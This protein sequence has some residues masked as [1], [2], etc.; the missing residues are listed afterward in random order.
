MNKKAAIEQ[1]ISFAEQ[2]YDSYG[3]EL[4]MNLYERAVGNEFDEAMKEYSKLGEQL[5]NII[6]E[7]K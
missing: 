1:L 4:E 6:E 5:Q 2:V 7:L 3:E